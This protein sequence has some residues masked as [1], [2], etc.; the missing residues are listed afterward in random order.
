MIPTLI[1][2]T[3]F[4][5][6]LSLGVFG[7]AA[8]LGHEWQQRAWSWDPVLAR[9]VFDPDIGM[10][11]NTAFLAGAA[12]LI[13]IMLWGGTL[14]RGLLRMIR[15]RKVDTGSDPRIAPR[16]VSEHIIKGVDGADLHVEVHGVPQGITLVLTHGWGL[17]GTEWN[18]LKRHLAGTFRLVVWDEPGLGQSTRPKD[19][20]YSVEK[21]ARNLHAVVE[22]A[23]TGEKAVILVGHSI[24]GMIML[25]YARLYQEALQSRVRGLVLTHT[26]PKNPVR[27]TS[28]AAFY[29]A[30]ETPVLKPLM[31]LTIALSPLLW[32]LNWLSYRNGSAHLSTMRSSFGGTENWQQ[33]E[34][35]TAFQ[36]QASPAVVARGMLGMMNYNAQ[37]V[38]TTLPV[39]VLV[40]GG[41]KDGVTKLAASRMMD[42][43]IPHSHLRILSPAKHL[44]LVEHHRE[45]AAAVREFAYECLSNCRE[46]E[47]LQE[48]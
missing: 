9:S 6:L 2:Q 45:Y 37:S 3:W 19:R 36:L 13:F 27:T 42:A 44:G 26:T 38:L 39:P 7:A 29:T 33:I 32:V 28:G 14:V 25:T 34:F 5:G 22:F 30:I 11:S 12:V 23:A 48:N 15:P 41:D 31:Y 43:A 4:L 47:L 35:A 16:A 21:L 24:G 20:D 17:N 1:F 46:E 8:Y 40:V 10:N 18:D